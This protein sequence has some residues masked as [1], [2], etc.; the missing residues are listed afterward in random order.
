MTQSVPLYD[1]PGSRTRF[2]WLRTALAFL[3]V[4]ALMV[5]GLYVRHAPAWSLV[6]VVALA[7]AMSALALTRAMRLGPRE[8]PSA[9]T[10]LI[11]SF[12]TIIAVTAM[13][14]AVLLGVIR[15]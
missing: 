3:A 4:S 12:A 6:V 14:A 11:V 8:S 7:L 9:P 15:P 2:A 1:E 5:R 13:C 10:W